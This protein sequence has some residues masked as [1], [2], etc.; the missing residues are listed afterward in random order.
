M[1]QGDFISPYAICE[2]QIDTISDKLKEAEQVMTSAEQTAENP[3]LALKRPER[4][5]F[6]RSASDGSL[7]KKV[8]LINAEFWGECI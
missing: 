1:M 2:L 3:M 6:G 4:P 8:V 5:L 7:N